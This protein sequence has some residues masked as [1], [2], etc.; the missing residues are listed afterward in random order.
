[1]LVTHGGWIFRAGSHPVVVDGVVK[2]FGGTV[3]L[4]GVDLAVPAGS[5]VALVG[6]SGCG[7]TTLLRLLTGVYRPSEG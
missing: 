1:M 5:I 4:G 6:P 3:A 2:A 7:K